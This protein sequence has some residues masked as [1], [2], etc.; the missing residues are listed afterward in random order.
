MKTRGNYENLSHNGGA[1][2]FSSEQGTTSGASQPLLRLLDCR[3]I[4]RRNTKFWELSLKAKEL[5][6]NQ[7]IRN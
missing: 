2:I 1:K 7:P 5:E 3:K 4:A 6:I